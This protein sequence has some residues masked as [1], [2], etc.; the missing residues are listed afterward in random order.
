[1]VK[2]NEIVEVYIEDVVFPNKGIGYVE[3]KKL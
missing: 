3:D 2:K 1:M